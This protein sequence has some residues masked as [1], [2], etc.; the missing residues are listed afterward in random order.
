MG[1]VMGMKLFEYEFPRWKNAFKFAGYMMDL[2]VV[3]LTIYL[4]EGWKSDIYIAYL[5]II[6]LSLKALSIRQNLLLGLVSGILYC[7]MAL[8]LG[9]TQSLWD[10]VFLLR[11]PL[12]LIGCISTTLIAKSLGYTQES[13]QTAKEYLGVSLDARNQA[14]KKTVRELELINNIIYS[15]FAVKQISRFW[16]V[17]AEQLRNFFQCERVTFFWKRPSGQLES[18]YADGVQE[19]IFINLGEGFAGSS[20]LGEALYTNDPY[21]DPKFYSGVDY[22]LGFKTKNLLVCPILRGKEV[23]GLIELINKESGFTA[24]DLETMTRLTTHI[25]V[26]YEKLGAD[27][28]RLQL[29][30]ELQMRVREQRRIEL[31]LKQARD[32][33]IEAATT[34]SEYLASMSHELRTPL[35]AITGMTNLLLESPLSSQQKEYA[36]AVQRSG[37]ALLAVVNDIL[38]LSKIESGKLT[39]EKLDFDLCEV[40]ETTAEMLATQA[41]KKGVELMIMIEENLPRILN[42]DPTR[43][44]QVL[45]NLVSNAVKFTDHGS[46]FVQ[47]RKGSQSNGTMTLKFQ[48]QDTG[49]GMAQEALS[50]LFK[51]FVQA[52]KSITR[53][54]GGTGLGLAISKRLVEMME[55]EMGVTSELKQGSTF[56]FTLPFQKPPS[57]IP[58][59][60]VHPKIKDY[61]IIVL[62]ENQ[63]TQTY[64]EHILQSWGAS[65]EGISNVGEVLPLLQ[66]HVKDQK[67][68]HI[69]LLDWKTGRADQI[70]S[71]VKDLRDDPTFSNLRLIP[72][73]PMADLREA[74]H[75]APLGISE[76]ITK[77]IR[78]ASLEKVILKVM[79][80]APASEKILPEDLFAIAYR[81][82]FR[83]LIA[84]DNPINQHL[85]VIQFERLGYSAEAVGD[86]T[87]VLEALGKKSYNILFSDCHMPKMDGFET[88]KAIRSQKGRAIEHLPIIAMTASV[89]KEDKDQC[90]QAGM[91]DYITKPMEKEAL[92]AIL[93]QWDIAVDLKFLSELFEGRSSKDIQRLN[94]II[95]LYLTSGMERVRELHQAIRDA[96]FETVA[97][98]AHSLKGSSGTIGAPRLQ[99]LCQR[100]EEFLTLKKYS[101]LSQ[102]IEV[103]EY[104]MKRTHQILEKE[105]REPTFSTPA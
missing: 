71:L 74:A 93:T 4:L 6:V 35:N 5:A 75:F 97:R 30:E 90:F 20:A 52:D 22:M 21:K 88:A 26:L 39:F 43:I 91:N 16:P 87:E 10:P 103:L 2:L 63:T 1:F 79:E 48:V 104:E 18:L 95:R 40:V 45:L 81:K 94:D 33:A 15:S 80:E 34:K 50:N 100:V 86:G 58:V 54:Y 96:D 89:E 12:L 61:R 67:M 3:S 44:R 19:K 101:E 66:K 27:L 38:D 46:V 53:K 31:E 69:L 105:I 70:A 72:M 8:K 11:I 64:V 62:D 24:S 98:L 32:M 47:V 65:V 68:D 102:L 28:D 92:N 77:P 41:Q 17:L 78:I 73:V 37:G 29:Q 7:I 57:P 42:G 36:Q 99:Y 9:W 14:L 25:Q 84:D 83:I 59:V 13:L 55:G 76:F 56:W 85:A 51:S 82:Y 23:I 60:A 49:I